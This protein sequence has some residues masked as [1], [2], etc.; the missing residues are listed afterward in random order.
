MR[1]LAWLLLYPV[2]LL[3]CEGPSGQP[4]TPGEPGV[5]GLPGVTG[6]TGP[7]GATGP[8]GPEGPTGPAGSTDGGTS[9]D[10]GPGGR[11]AYLTA[12]GLKIEL[13]AAGIDSTGTATVSVRIT[14]GDDLPLDKD[15]LYTRGTVSLSF[16][17]AWL[18]VESDGR[19]GQYT[20][21]TTRSVTSPIT[22]LTVDQASTDRGGTLVEIGAGAG[23]YRYTFGIPA[24]N[25]D[26]TKTHTIGVYGTRTIETQRAFADA[27]FDFVPDG[28]AVA[29]RRRVITN[30]ACNGCHAQ[31]AA[32]G[33]AR[34]KVEL[35]ILCHTPQTVDP[36]TG[37]TVDFNVMVHKIHRGEHLPSVVAGEPYQI[38]GFNQTV[39]DYSTVAYPQELRLCTTCHAGPDG[40]LWST[41][42]AQ[43]ACRSCHDRT[44]FVDPPPAGSTL[45]RGGQ[46]PENS[47]CRICHPS[48]GN[49]APIVT[50][51]LNPFND[52]ASA[53]ITAVLLNVSNSGPGQLPTVRFSITVNGQPRDILTAPLTSLRATVA[54][55]NSDYARYWQATIQGTGAAGA[56][57]AVD[58]ANGVFDYTF[59][60]PIPADAT[61]SYT[62]ALEATL[63]ANSTAPRFA[64]YPPLFPFVVTGSSTVAEPRRQVIDAA[65]CNNCHFDLSF[66]GGSRRNAEYC[67]LCHNP[68]NINDERMSRLEDRA[69]LVH[70]VDAKMMIHRIHAGERLANDYIL[71]GNPAPTRANPVGTPANFK[72]LRF[73]GIAGN[74]AQCHRPSTWALP[75]TGPRLSSREQVRHCLEN[76]A[77]DADNY[78]DSGLWVASSTTTL[79]P[80]TAACLGCHDSAAAAAHAEVNTTL[81]GVEACDVCH[82]PGKDEDVSVVH[83]IR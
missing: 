81:S 70:S 42:P 36:D 14:D 33:G 1:R 56:P 7:S 77:A 26:R 76:P 10:A 4:G 27:T 53:R 35:C 54:G 43:P 38:I 6:A 60:T 45:H 2:T 8:T 52:P 15:G 80:A 12:D 48:T 21:Y 30:N 22:H 29:M 73:P 51:H 11:N 59:T 67:V 39:E 65:K 69:V 79:G 25:V 68:N 44:S 5:N 64:A 17:L 41:R 16:V 46:Q 83:P 61:G 34:Q 75:L 23:T 24:Q 47:P 49:I 62:M 78:C 72:E 71:G 63:Q 18:A 37:N 20:A 3:A 58:A 82:G 32:H 31:L 28:S 66:H 9:P 19:V 13:L 40:A 55:P 57:V 74:C 50:A